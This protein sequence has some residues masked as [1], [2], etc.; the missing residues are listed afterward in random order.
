MMNMQ[1]TQT[2]FDKEQFLHHAILNPLHGDVVFSIQIKN[3][4]TR[5]DMEALEVALWP[6][7][8]VKKPFQ[9]Y[10]NERLQDENDVS[11]ASFTIPLDLGGIPPPYY[12]SIFSEDEAM[13][14][15]KY[16]FHISWKE[17]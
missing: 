11:L 10:F 5:E 9:F 3:E 17:S 1:G 13:D 7:N 2:S 15:E 12:L 16:Q 8:L 14:L 6:H 4:V